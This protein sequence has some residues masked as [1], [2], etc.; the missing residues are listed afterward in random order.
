MWSFATIIGHDYD[1]TRSA[2]L[3]PCSNLTAESYVNRHMSLKR[4]RMATPASGCFVLE[5]RI[6]A[7]AAQSL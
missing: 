5:Y 1:A 4:Q 7:D 2:V 3:A 6:G